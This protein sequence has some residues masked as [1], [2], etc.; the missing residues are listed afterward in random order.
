MK[1]VI[2]E[3]SCFVCE[4]ADDELSNNL[5]YVGSTTISDSSAVSNYYR[6]ENSQ[7]SS[8]REMLDNL[9]AAGVELLLCSELGIKE[10]RSL[11]EEPLLKDYF[12]TI[13]STN[14]ISARLRDIS[15]QLIRRILP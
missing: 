11:P 3:K 13:F 8:V 12:D 14:S 2:F 1:K 6:A 4:P 9:K 7:K 10:K 15:K 5:R